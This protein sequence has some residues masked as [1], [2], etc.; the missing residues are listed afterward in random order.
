MVKGALS[1][2]ACTM[3][4]SWYLRSEAALGASEDSFATVDSNDL[5]DDNFFSNNYHFG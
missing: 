4:W 1:K 3:R 2:S 5:L